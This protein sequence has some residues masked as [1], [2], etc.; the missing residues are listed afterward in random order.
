[1]QRH[2]ARVW[3]DGGRSR[4]REDAGLAVWT[5]LRE[6]FCSRPSPCTRSVCTCD[7]CP[8]GKLLRAIGGKDVAQLRSELF[9]PVIKIRSLPRGRETDPATSVAS[10]DYQ[11]GLTGVP[12]VQQTTAV[13]QTTGRNPP[14]LQIH[15]YHGTD[16]VCTPVRNLPHQTPFH[17]ARA[18]PGQ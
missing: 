18:G 10:W 7:R 3:G 17:Q 6:S 8:W 2:A 5:G 4:P 1:M 9:A 16:L 15:M 12:P 13:Q 11:R 14:L